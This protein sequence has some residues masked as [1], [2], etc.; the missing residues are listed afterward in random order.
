VVRAEQAFGERVVRALRQAEPAA[1]EVRVLEERTRL[2]PARH[3][4]AALRFEQRE[5]AAGVDLLL[6]DDAPTARDGRERTEDEAA[7]PEERHVSPPR[8]LRAHAQRLADAAPRGGERAVC[9]HDGLRLR[10]GAGREEDRGD[11]VGDTLRSTASKKAS[12]AAGTSSSQRSTPRV[13]PRRRVPGASRITRRTAGNVATCSSPGAVSSSP[14]GRA[15]R[16]AR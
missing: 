2:V 11:V 13:P 6:E 5:R 9:V 1:G 10:R 15:V 3:D 4:R 16:S 14:G 7:A 12:S 8:V